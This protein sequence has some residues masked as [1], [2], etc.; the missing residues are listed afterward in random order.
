MQL[1]FA[2]ILLSIFAY[3]S[4]FV[5][6]QTDDIVDTV[7]KNGNF[8]TLIRLL[9]AADLDNTLRGRG[10]FTVFAPDDEAFEKISNETIDDLLKPENKEKLASILKYHVLGGNYTAAAIKAMTLP[11]QIETLLTQKFIVDTSGNSVKVN[12]ATVTTADVFATNGVIHIIDTVLIP[13]TDIVQTATNNT[14]FKILVTA[15][16][17]ASLVTT[18][19]GPGPFT[20]FAPT[21]AAFAKLPAGV[22]DELVKSE[23]KDS[24][25]KI[26]QYHVAS[27]IYTT[28]L[29]NRLALP[30]N[31]TML[32]G[33][34]TRLNKNG[35]DI[36]INDATVTQVDIFNS[37]GM[38]HSID[39]VILPPLDIVEITLTD[40]NFKNLT[41]AL[42]AANLTV[43]LK[44]NGP[45]T[46]FAPTDAAF[47][48]LPPGTLDDLL[49]P[50]NKEKLTNILTYHVLNERKTTADIKGMILPAQLNTLSG[51]KSIVDVNGDSVKLNTATITKADVSGTNGIV[52][53]IDT[54]LL[55]PTDVVQTAIND[56]N[57]K[58]LVQAINAAS[59]NETLRGSGPFTVFA[60]TDTAF[61]KFPAGVVD[62]LVKPENQ[63]SLSKIIQHHVTSQLIT[64]A[65]IN[66]MA[67][68]FNI[69]M[70][71]GGTAR[72]NK[73]GNTVKIDAASVTTADIY[74]TNGMIHIIDSVIL[75]PLD[76]VE[77]AI[78]SGNFQTLIK[79]LKAADLFG[80]LKST[81]P[82]T[83]LAPT[84]DAFNKLPP[85]TLDDLLKP[86]NKD[87]LANILKYHVL[88]ERKTAADIKALTL[89]AQLT[90]LSGVKF[91]VDINGD[92]VKLNTA[93]VIKADVSGTNGIIHV[94]DT[95]LLPPTDV[96]QTAINDGNFKT[97]LNALI[98]AGLADTLKGTGPF[99]VFAPTDAAFAKLPA[100]LLDE[101]SKTDNKKVLA[102]IL[103]YHVTSQLVTAPSINRMAL[104]FNITMLAGGT[105]RLNKEGTTVKINNASITKA[106]IFNTN[107]MIHVI[108]SVILPPFDVF[109]RALVDGTFK[110]LV[111]ALRA[112]DL[113]D[114]L[115]GNGPF[116][117]FAPNDAAFAKLPNGTL[118]DLLKP[119]NK[120]KLAN[121]LKY[122][123]INGRKITSDEFN[124]SERVE[125][126]AGGSVDITKNGDEIKVNG[127]KIIVKD[128]ETT[129]GIIHVIESVLEPQRTSS[130]SIHSSQTFL[131]LLASA[132]LYA[133]RFFF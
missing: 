123:V 11:T 115:Q 79:A 81:G 72:L 58:I 28:A 67:L 50:E 31:I 5:E 110:T 113:A 108:D 44:G 126:L 16:N 109:E 68:P 20:V 32:A 18:L 83:V 30:M 97:L 23:N 7:I 8:K 63:G 122:H 10:P 82:F 37:N 49:R 36:T 3:Q 80:T 75:P 129:N 76:V 93:T 40:G 102:K 86:E 45:F 104:P 107:G 42:V 114:T 19:K 94:I 92:S 21:D 62:E 56:G 27:Q 57:F 132:L 15:L 125:M 1:R 116:T 47:S 61:N 111:T 96:V 131:V 64:T 106:D 78:T 53:V 14:N 77:T 46:V 121:R 24:L 70:L 124:P 101:L 90:T 12:D 117:V 29:T 100:G 88:G 41:T 39:R 69:T 6:G 128:V 66:R 99:T 33:G 95:V 48:K 127:V 4:T 9:Q 119:E 71:A 35:D 103:Q 38:I 51:I 89:P 112:A 73:D 98:V 26:L 59:L 133:Y 22:L 65:S 13:P 52:H 130:M 74:N 43:T 2:I 118:D 55:P 120:A 105:A 85:G 84:D 60:P 87:K 54:V 34:T 25:V 91:I 17:A